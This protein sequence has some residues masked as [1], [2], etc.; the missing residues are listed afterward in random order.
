MKSWYEPK[1]MIHRT[2]YQTNCIHEWTY[3]RN[4]VSFM[5][6]KCEKCGLVRITDLTADK[7]TPDGKGR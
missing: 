5:Y 2:I 7:E 1:D 6:E 3:S 4:Y